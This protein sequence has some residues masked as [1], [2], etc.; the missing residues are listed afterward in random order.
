M[1]KQSILQL[2]WWVVQLAFAWLVGEGGRMLIAGSAG[3]LLRWMSTERR[4]RD[5]VFAAAGG[6]VSAYFFWPLTLA[7]LHRMAPE[8]AGPDAAAMAGC[9]TG[10]L[11]MSA[12]KIVVSGFEAWALKQIGEHDNG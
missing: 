10:V 8:L 1:E 12:V 3:G 7:G 11:G 2:V 9:L 4:L 6:G 5:G